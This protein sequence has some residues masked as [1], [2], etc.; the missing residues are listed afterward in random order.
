M[1]MA[2]LANEDESLEVIVFP[3]ELASVFVSHFMAITRKLV[4]T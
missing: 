2:A 1:S 3:T 4:V